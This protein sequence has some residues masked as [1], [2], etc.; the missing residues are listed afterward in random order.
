MREARRH[1]LS[2]DE[3]TPNLVKTKINRADELRTTEGRILRES[4]LALKSLKA[5][6]LAVYIAMFEASTRTADKHALAAFWL[7]MHVLVKNV[8]ASSLA[9]NETKRDMVMNISA[10][11][12]DSL[13]IR[14]NDINT[15]D[16]AA[17]LDVTSVVNAGNAWKDH[18]TQAEADIYTAYREVGTTDGMTVVI[19]GDNY[20]GR[21]NRADI[22]MFSKFNNRVILASLPGMEIRDDIRSLLEEQGTEHHEV[23]RLVDAMEFKPDLAILSRFQRERYDGVNPRTGDSWDTDKISRDYQTFMALT[24]E[25]MVAT[26]K[27]TKIM[28]PLPRGPELPDDEDPR[29]VIWPQVKNAVW[30]TVTDYEYIFGIGPFNE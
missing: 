9:K 21:V 17:S 30:M 25:V 20:N 22:K 11:G 24:S 5:G 8:K 14:D 23:E 15:P 1:I 27:K 2:T 28:H 18:P 26:P 10:Q 19:A 4:Q 7:D 6:G 29:V 12:F 16:M 3:L 13:V